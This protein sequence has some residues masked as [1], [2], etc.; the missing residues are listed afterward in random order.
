MKSPQAGIFALGDIAHGFF[1]FS[2]RAGADAHAALNA[3][4]SVH[5]PR[6]TVGGAN[7]VIRFR[8]TSTEYL[9][10]LG[11]ASAVERD[12]DSPSAVGLSGGHGRLEIISPIIRSCSSAACPHVCCQSGCVELLQP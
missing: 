5:E 8:P 12:H 9:E 7:R 1:E 10:I 11:F 2:L 6:A 3:L 4:V